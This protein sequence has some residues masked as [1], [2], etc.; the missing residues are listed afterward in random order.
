MHHCNHRQLAASALHHRVFNL[1]IRRFGGI[2]FI[3]VHDAS[4]AAAWHW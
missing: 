2:V 4:G 1:R 3:E